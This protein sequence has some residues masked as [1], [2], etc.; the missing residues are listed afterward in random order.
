MIFYKKSS[1]GEFLKSPEGI[2]TNILAS[3]LQN[4]EENGIIGKS[5]H[6]DSKAKFLYKLTEKGIDLIPIFVEIH[7]WY[8]KYS[9]V[10]AEFKAAVSA[11]TQDKEAYVRSI[12]DAWRKA[13]S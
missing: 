2:A 8:A 11:A 7:L 12:K 6:P 9:G 13:A 1:Y 3:R 5:E 4:L 10:P